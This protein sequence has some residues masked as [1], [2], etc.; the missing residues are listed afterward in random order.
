[1]VGEEKIKKKRVK[2][3]VYK[4]LVFMNKNQKD[5]VCK[6]KNKSEFIRNL[7]QKAM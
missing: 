3:F 5:F 2:E 6:Q 4:E 1:M 7:I